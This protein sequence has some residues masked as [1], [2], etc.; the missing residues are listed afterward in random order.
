MAKVITF[1]SDY[2]ASACSPGQFF[3]LRIDNSHDPLLRRP[4]SLHRCSRDEGTIDLLYCIKGRGTRALAQMLP[5]QHVDVLG[6]LGQ[7]FPSPLGTTYLVGGGMG[8]AP[9]LSVAQSLPDAS[10]ATL[11]NGA[12]TKSALLAVDSFEALDIPVTIATDDGSAGH[13][14]TV[15]A[16][17]ETMPLPET[18]FCCGPDPMLKAVIRYCLASGISC[19]ASVEQRMACGIGM[20]RACA[21]TLSRE[22]QTIIGRVCT[23]G[24]VFAAEEL[25]AW[26]EV[27]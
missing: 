26:A 12:R 5:G 24:P 22:G 4:L 19:W 13:R 21:I 8:V 7:G 20:C 25:A 23:D 17:L 27:L 1:R 11:L 2:F 16:L 3:H 15:S 10:Q 9:L 6:P 14:G 18:V